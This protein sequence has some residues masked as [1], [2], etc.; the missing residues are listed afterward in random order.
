MR[1]IPTPASIRPSPPPATRIALCLHAWYT[2]RFYQRVPRTSSMA[3]RW[4]RFRI[5][6]CHLRILHFHSRLT[7]RC[8]L[9]PRRSIDFT[10]ICYQHGDVYP[11]AS[12]SRHSLAH[13]STQRT[14]TLQLTS[15]LRHPR[16][17][18]L[19]NI[20]ETLRTSQPLGEGYIVQEGWATAPRETVDMTAANLVRLETAAPPATAKSNLAIGWSRS[21]ADA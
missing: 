3:R 11:P 14:A 18:S 19:P 1:I 9:S 21:S 16:Q 2:A 10:C 20:T 5:G 4:T 15:R 13:P 12:D 7:L 17:S 8:F 6:M